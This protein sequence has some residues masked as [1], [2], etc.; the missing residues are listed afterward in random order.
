ME[1]W[2]SPYKEHVF[3]V[4]RVVW[5]LLL[6]M[7]GMQKVLGVLTDHSPPVGSQLWVGGVIELTTGLL[8]AVGLF[9]SWAAFL[10]SGMLAVAYMQF[11]WQFQMGA[12]FFP[13]KNQG[14][15]AVVYC[16]LFLYIACRGAGPWSIDAKLQAN[17]TA[18]AR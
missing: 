3:T 7:H 16:F 15:P 12:N 6:S 9:T 10:A 1:R 17:R 13:I 11:H 5:G 8:M 14:E 18:A 4:A 2:L